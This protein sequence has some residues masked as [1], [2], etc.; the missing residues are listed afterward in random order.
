MQR[1]PFKKAGFIKQQAGDDDGDKRSGGVPDDVPHH[2][3]V[4][5]L[6]HAKKQCEYRAKHGAPAYAQAA[7]LPDNQGDGEQ[8]NK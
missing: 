6:D 4:G 8:K 1:A 5:K 2:C 7:R 3:N